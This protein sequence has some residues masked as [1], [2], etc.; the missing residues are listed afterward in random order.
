M[1]SAAKYVQFGTF[2]RLDIPA[3]SNLVCT[4]SVNSALP[5][6]GNQNVKFKGVPM[7]GGSGFA[8]AS[9]SGLTCVPSAIS[10][11]I[12]NPQALQTTKGIIAAAVSNTQLDLNDRLQPWDDVA[13]GCI[14][15]LRPRLMSAGKLA[16]RGVQ[17]N[18]YPL[19]MA[20]VADFLPMSYSPDQG[21]TLNSAAVASTGWA[22]IVVIN[23]SA[24]DADP[25]ELQFLVSVEWRVRFDISNPAVA[26]HA[27]HG[28]TDDW[29]WNRMLQNAVNMGNGVLDIVERVASAGQAVQA[30]AGPAMRRAPLM[31]TAA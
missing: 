20:A 24:G 13:T 31:L 3:W 25:V 15:Y 8:I 28:V 22:P 4:E 17:L 23:E 18:S 14:S 21:G 5:I 27:H 29:N 26:S 30:I 6:N 1:K 12:M 16:L 19:N 11:Q 9:G 7:P 10:V 2:Q